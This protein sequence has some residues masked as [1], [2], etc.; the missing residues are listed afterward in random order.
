MLF[1]FRG[2][3]THTSAV[4][5]ART[6]GCARQAVRCASRVSACRRELNSLDAAKPRERGNPQER[7]RAEIHTTRPQQPSSG[8][9]STATNRNDMEPQ[10][11]IELP[12]CVGGSGLQSVHRAATSNGASHLAQWWRLKYVA[13]HGRQR[14]AGCFC[15]G[16]RGTTMPFQARR[17]CIVSAAQ[18]N[19][20]FKP[21]PN[22]G[23][24]GPGNRYGVHFLSPGPGVPPLVPA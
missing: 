12:H 7:G 5:L 6:L 24:P 14:G 3:A 22:G 17:Q 23:P 8:M 21:S 10:C 11:Y 13:C 16:P 19:P 15:G 2:Q 18:P 1:S 20:S 9:A 4:S